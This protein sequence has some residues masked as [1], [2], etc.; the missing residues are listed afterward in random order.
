MN[1]PVFSLFPYLSRRRRF[2]L[3]IFQLMSILS[4]FLE[5]GSLGSL[6]PF[7]QAILNPKN[8]I[9]NLPIGLS[10]MNEKN[11]ILFMGIFFLVIVVTSTVVRV[12][13]IW[14]QQNLTANIAADLST[15][16]FNKLL[17]RPYIW[18]IT[19]NSSEVITRLT[20]DVNQVRSV[21]LAG[22][23]LTFSSLIVLSLGFTL[24]WISPQI[25][26]CATFI[27]G[28]SYITI[29]R[30][31]RGTFYREGRLRIESHQRSIKTLQES[32]GGIRD[33]LLDDCQNVFLDEY[34][35]SVNIS[36][37]AVAR[38]NFKAQVPRYLIEGITILLI[39]GLAVFLVLQDQSMNN[40]I[41]I[42]GSFTLG[43]YKIL[44]PLQNIFVALAT[45][46]S[47]SSSIERMLPYLDETTYSKSL[48]S[49]ASERNVDFKLEKNIE[50]R[51]VWFRYQENQDW[52]IKDLNLTIP[53]GSRVGFVGPTGSGKSTSIDLIMGLLK[54]TK[55]GLFLDGY[56]ATKDSSLMKDWQNHIAHVPQHIYLSD[57]SF[58]ENIAFGVPI[59]E[60]DLVKVK[61]S[62]Q[63]AQISDFIDEQ[64]LG[65]SE[66]I[67]ERGIG[68]SGGQRQRIGIA[69]ALYKGA[70][71][72]LL[73]EATS[74]LDNKTEKKFIEELL[75]NNNEL[76]IIM[77]AHRLTTVRD[78]SLIYEFIEGKIVN[79]GTYDFLSKKSISFRLLAQNY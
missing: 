22:L 42:L 67:G 64:L 76:T 4:S 59:Q 26:L 10:G 21:I 44:Q 19:Q 40:F 56:D 35:Y 48:A 5:I 72:L 60:I 49:V 15:Q 33:I 79:H 41:P 14:V 51:D 12:S 17:K 46:K 63:K 25:T 70:Y 71:V 43:A 20:E 34:R 9:K 23:N 6:Y 54:P 2:Q 38:I 77:I 11:T 65:Y 68:L 18:H 62:A 50:L 47:N 36:R 31:T 55:G 3:L 16:C 1:F 30:L 13:T 75:S 24:V 27:F 52:V 45:M 61:E 78:C 58:A 57:S 37:K 29:Y 74:A 66:T 8:V 73:D 39:S 69:R 32:L 28:G 53:I 7:L